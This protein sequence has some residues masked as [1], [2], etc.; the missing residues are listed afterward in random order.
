MTLPLGRSNPRALER[1]FD[2]SGN[3]TPGQQ[4]RVL[5]DIC[6][7]A[8]AAGDAHEAR[9]RHLEPAHEAKDRR[10]SAPGGAEHRHDLAAGQP[11]RQI[12]NDRERTVV[13]GQTLHDDHSVVG[14]VERPPRSG[15][16]FNSSDPPTRDW[17]SKSSIHVPL[18]EAAP[19]RAGAA[20]IVFSA[21]LC[22]FLNHPFG[23]LAEG[24]VADG[25]LRRQWT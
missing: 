19:A 8:T 1:Q 5:K 11:E 13:V 23:R 10:L 16:P 9:G 7:R 20:A 15:R 24:R 2:V 14:T 4:G 22:I 25:K 18:S 6:N 3:S 12:P 17:F 21:I